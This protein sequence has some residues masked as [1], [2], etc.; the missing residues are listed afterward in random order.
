MVRNDQVFWDHRGKALKL[1][2]LTKQGFWEEV[3]N[4]P[5]IQL[6]KGKGCGQVEGTTNIKSIGTVNSF[7]INDAQQSLYVSCALLKQL[8]TMPS[9]GI[10]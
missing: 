5:P 7:K 9:E 4:K 8:Q 10:N 1:A 3:I 6:A 2:S